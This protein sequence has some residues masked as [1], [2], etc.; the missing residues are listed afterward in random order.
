VLMPAEVALSSASKSSDAD[1]PSVTSDCTPEGCCLTEAA[2]AGRL[3]ST[4]AFT[5]AE[6]DGLDD[7]CCFTDA[8]E[9]GRLRSALAAA[10]PDEDGLDE[11]ICPAEGGRL[12]LMPAGVAPSS[13]PKSSDADSPSVTSDCTTAPDTRTE[14]LP[15][16]PGPRDAGRL[17]AAD[18]S[19]ANTAAFDDLR[20][21]S[22][23]AVPGRL[24]EVDSNPFAVS[25]R[26]VDEPEALKTG[27]GVTEVFSYPS[28]RSS[29]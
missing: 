5:P 16:E 20:L 10:P 12:I 29:S 4:L 23:R 19:E 18:E 17:L 28:S 22:A 24:L 3:R 6:D 1:S 8:A 27:F 7:G 15:A 21:R 26:G 2:E 11:R 9:A 25:N 13:A 14:A